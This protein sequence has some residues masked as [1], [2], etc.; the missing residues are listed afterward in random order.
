MIVFLLLPIFLI[1]KYVED[2]LFPAD[3]D[4][5]GVTYYL[6]YV[7]YLASKSLGKK[8]VLF[9]LTSLFE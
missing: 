8:P 5:M 9:E 7:I 1:Y 3:S 4:M 2:S 6:A